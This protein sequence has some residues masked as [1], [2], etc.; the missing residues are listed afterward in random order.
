MP[1][2]VEA[3]ILLG[4][5]RSQITGEKFMLS[6]DVE[7]VDWRAVMHESVHQA[8][9]MLAFDA[10][11]A[12]E[13]QIPLEVYEHWMQLAYAAMSNNMKVMHSQNELVA[14]L[15]AHKFNYVILKG[16]AAA[17]DYPR[18][19]LRSLGDVDFL[20]DPAKQNEIQCCLLEHGYVMSNTDHV[21]HITFK[22]PG[23]YLEM[24]F[25]I[26]G[27]PLGK[28]GDWVFAAMKDVL[29]EARVLVVE[30]A[31]F[32]AADEI[33]HALILLLH[34]QGH[35]LNEGLGIRH[36]CDWACFINR[37]SHK[38]YWEETLLPFLKKLG[39][40]TYASV[41]TK[42]ASVYLGSIC[43]AWARDVSEDLCAE[44]MFDIFEGGN[45]GKKDLVR[46]KSGLM[47]SQEGKTGTAHG[48][49]RNLYIGLHRASMKRYPIVKKIKA[50]HP[51][52]DVIHAIRYL[53]LSTVGKKPFLT[54][55][56]VRAG[57]RR[58]LYE[59]LRVF[60]EVD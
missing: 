28:K 5:V 22:R 4:L 3:R 38:A 24:H 16:L 18:P 31:K 41:M 7:E 49:L 45:F 47:I 39:L 36:L 1:L 14:L 8:I 32:Y 23:A 26:A 55:M 33:R 30:G 56:A 42:T 53:V 50:L 2:T 57:N 11:A 17:A 44:I 40:Y 37:T 43:P 21:C 48:R 58:A 10:A 12:V 15:N 25:Q 35:M 54:E 60:E 29:E 6:T 27:I 59:K 20:I 9:P 51:L 34:M 19:E 13:N 52:F 46:A